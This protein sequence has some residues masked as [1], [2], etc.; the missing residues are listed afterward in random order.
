[1]ACRHHAERHAIGRCTAC[2]SPCCEECAARVDGIL[3]C[4]RCVPGAAAAAGGSWRSL[5]AL[6]ADMALVPLAWLALGF[7]LQAL[8]AGVAVIQALMAKSLGR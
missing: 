1:V 4:V 7:S 5:S 8:V 3:R 6:V 2:Q